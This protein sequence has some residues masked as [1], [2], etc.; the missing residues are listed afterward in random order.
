MRRFTVATL[1]AFWLTNSDAQAAC[2]TPYTPEQLGGDIAALSTALAA[3]NTE[4]F[5][6][7]GESLEAGL[8][9]HQQ[10]LAPVLFANIY[11]YIGLQAYF[12][13]KTSRGAEWFRLAIELDPTFEWD[14]SELGFDDPIRAA[15]DA[16]RGPASSEKVQVA[17]GAKL[18]IP[19]GKRLAADGRMFTE[20][21]LTTGRPHVL[22]VIDSAT[23]T[24]EQT[25]VI[26]GNEIPETLL[27]ISDAPA[28]SA[29][30]AEVA[31]ERIAR[32][33]PPLK[34]P[35]LIGG[36]VLMA[37]GVGLYAA[38]FSTRSKFDAATTLAEAEDHRSSTNSLVLAAS[39]A[40]I[41]GA[42]LT[43]VGISLDGGP[44]LRWNGR[45]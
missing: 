9:C 16:E 39:A 34:T 41:G 33:R 25:W 18:N 3:K 44:G 36:G 42:G 43:Y 2:P 6:M 32:Q 45:F 7:A 22:Q 1:L 31:F 14:M 35:A 10:P 40:L 21:S 5:Q 12:K 4:A 15:Y 30:G 23:N 27:V 8:P 37:A 19:A 20:A 17:D 29:G 13:G 24:V 26:N 28:V 11:R 38:S